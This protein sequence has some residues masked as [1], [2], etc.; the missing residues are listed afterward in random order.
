MSYRRIF[1]ILPQRIQ[2]WHSSPCVAEEKNKVSLEKVRMD[3]LQVKQK[4]VD[5]EKKLQDLNLM[6]QRAK[7]AAVATEEDVGYS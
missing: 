3:Q 4:L 6:I 5:L 2:Q 1:E 7:H